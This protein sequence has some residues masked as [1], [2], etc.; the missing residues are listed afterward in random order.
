[1]PLLLSAAAFGMAISGMHY[2][3]MAG[4]RIFPFAERVAGAPALSSDLLAIVV[5]VVAFLISGVFLL[6]LVPDRT[7]AR[8]TAAP[9]PAAA[10][11]L[12]EQAAP[13]PAAAPSLPEQAAPP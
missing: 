10:P 4:L 11:S 2:T 7:G 1:P 6:A 13:P 12:P 8:A 9:P 3:A 5:A